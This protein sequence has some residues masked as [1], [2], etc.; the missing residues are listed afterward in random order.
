MEGLRKFRVWNYQ[1]DQWTDGFVHFSRPKNE[2]IRESVN[3]DILGRVL[4]LKNQSEFAGHNSPEFK[5]WLNHV[6]LRKV[7]TDSPSMNEWQKI[8]NQ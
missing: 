3:F 7:A 5:K 8:Q 1:L 2:S 6:K 4:I